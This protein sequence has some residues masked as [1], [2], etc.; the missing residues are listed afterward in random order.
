MQS[1]KAFQAAL[2]NLGIVIWLS[3]WLLRHK[4]PVYLCAGF[5]QIPAQQKINAYQLPVD[6]ANLSPCC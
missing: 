6:T 3:C 4:T 2:L 5:N 1:W